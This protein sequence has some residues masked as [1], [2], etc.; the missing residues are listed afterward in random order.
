MGAYLTSGCLRGSVLAAALLA[1]NA[2]GCSASAGPA[3]ADAASEVNQT[4]D[5]AAPDV[6]EKRCGMPGV[7][8]SAYNAD[9]IAR[10]AG[11]TVLVGR[12]QQDSVGLTDFSGLEAVRK[13]EGV[14]NVFRCNGLRTLKGFDN[15]EVVEGNLFIHHNVNLESLAA[16]G[17]L[18]TITGDLIIESNTKLP[19]PEIDATRSR[20]PGS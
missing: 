2:S 11:C 17:K 4:P 15:L 5:L 16:L 12:F 18:H 1:A 7:Y 13:I 14:L 20:A 6:A 8:F 9:G 19:Q 10:L 3:T